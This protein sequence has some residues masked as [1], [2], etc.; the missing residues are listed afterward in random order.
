M[1]EI[2]SISNQ[3]G[4][5]GKT[6]T[7]VNLSSFLAILGKKILII[8]ADPQ[9][10]A[11]IS[12]GIS[13]NSFKKDI[14]H[15]LIGTVGIRDIIL[16]TNIENLDLI[17]SSISLVGLEKTFYNNSEDREFILKKLLSGI[18]NSYD[19]IIIDTPPTL[20]PVALNALVA[21]D[22]LIIPIQCE[23]FA[24]DGLSQLLNTIKIIRQKLNVA[25]KIKG[26]LPTMFSSTTNLSKQVYLEITNNFASHMFKFENEF[27]VI[28]R[29]VK[30]SEA[31]SFGEPIA[32]YDNKSAGAKAYYNLA[33]CIIENSSK[34]KG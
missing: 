29:N 13:K 24:L 6:T 14:Y 17:P 7:A 12:F 31:P 26:F 21:S 18:K 28:P 8:D 11:T 1:C 34:V 5:V 3:K 20:G 2:I 23:Y 10:N 15:A 22:S 4:G 33:L 30:L 27:I 19:Y 16:E 25:L 9:S 32:L